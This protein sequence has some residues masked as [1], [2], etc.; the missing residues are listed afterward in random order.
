MGDPNL[1]IAPSSKFRVDLIKSS[2]EGGFEN[3]WFRVNG[4][5]AVMHPVDRTDSDDPFERWGPGQV[6][7]E[8]VNLTG[9]LVSASTG[10][11]KEL[12]DWLNGWISGQA[13]TLENGTL[14]VLD[15]N[16]PPQVIRTINWKECFPLRYEAPSTQKASP[17]KLEET[18]TFRSNIIE[19]A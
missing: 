10:S 17:S 14:E 2:A 16:T 9:P 12:L 5:A 15:T 4:G 3:T 8:P 11:R 18:I 13:K 7:F 1:Q 19:D 6:S